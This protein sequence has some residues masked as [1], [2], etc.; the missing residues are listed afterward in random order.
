M[1][2]LSMPRYWRAGARSPPSGS[3]PTSKPA[4][5]GAALQYLLR[6]AFAVR[7]A[8][9][10]AVRSWATHDAGVRKTVKAIDQRRLSYIEGLLKR[11][12]IPAEIA[13]ARAQIL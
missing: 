7:S 9:E 4:D 1:S 5:E 6:R 12:G 10:V 13:R 2:M 11:S 8:L 3:S